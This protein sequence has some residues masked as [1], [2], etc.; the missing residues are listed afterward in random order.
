VFGGPGFEDYLDRDIAFTDKYVKLV[1]LAD[2]VEYPEPLDLDEIRA[3]MPQAVW[4]VLRTYTVRY[5]DP[6]ARELAI[7]FVLHG[8]SGLAGPWAASAE[9]GDELHMRGPGGAYTPDPEA[10]WHLLV[11][12]E[13]ALPA[14]GAAL[15][16]IDPQTPAVVFLEVDG[17]GDELPLAAGPLTEIT[18]LHRAPAEAGTTSLLDDAVRAMEFGPGRVQAFVHGEAGLLSTVRRHLRQERGIVR[19]DLSVSAYWRRGNTEE[20]FREWKAQQKA[21]GVAP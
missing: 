8:D 17:P 2:N 15:E 18:W 12:D 13:A 19:A 1:F 7:D 5:V 3:T 9:P 20:A 6:E 14:I 16:V 10:D 21:A 4:P 11:G